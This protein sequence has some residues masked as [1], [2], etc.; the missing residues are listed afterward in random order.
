[1]ERISEALQRAR[2]QRGGERLGMGEPMRPTA[3]PVH[4]DT[5]SPGAIVYTTTRTVHPPREKLAK[6][7]IVSGFDPCVFTDAFKVLS[8][9]VS[10]KLRVNNWNT[11]AVTSPS[12]H[13]GKTL[14]AVNLAISLAAELNQ[15][16][17]LVDADL[18][19][20]AVRETLALENGPGLRDYLVSHT[21][22][23][24]LLVHPGIPGLV[25]L[26]GGEP[27]LG[28]SELLGSRHMADLVHE[29][30]QRYRSRI[31]VFDL[32][33]LLSGAD[34]IAFAP[35]VEAALLVV[36]DGRT[37]AED[38]EHAAQL[39]GSTH[40]IGTVLNKSTESRGPADRPY[41][42]GN[43]RGH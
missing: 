20:C 5:R 4:G 36:E 19:R 6:R 7:R 35:H 29:V 15:T 21:P 10:Q 38:V 23:E 27:L 9:Q 31:V 3:V 16:A 11:L 14:V 37:R 34:A 17:L 24:Q 42:Y 8:T 33:P 18:R 26:P 40:L 39:L 32:P 12:E 43:G 22:V 13:E 1:M 25:V 30:K 28:S 41:T 2:E